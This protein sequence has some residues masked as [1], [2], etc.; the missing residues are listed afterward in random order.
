MTD[1]APQ[2][3]EPRLLRDDI[4]RRTADGWSLVGSRCP[5]G[6][7][8]FPV[9]KIC[10]ECL[11]ETVEPVELPRTGTVFAH[12]TVRMPAANFKP[13]YSIGYVTLTGGPRVFAHFEITEEE[14]RI[15]A[16]VELEVKPMWEE[17]GRPVIAYCFVSS[18]ESDHA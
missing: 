5:L 11:S 3:T 4:L 2:H 13:P 8:S 12:T 7:V 15:G 14:L 17:E 6:H 10:P 1:T 18:E 16:P 9:T